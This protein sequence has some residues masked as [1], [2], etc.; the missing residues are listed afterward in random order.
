MSYDVACILNINMFQLG[1]L[2]CG[3]C[4]F[5]VLVQQLAQLQLGP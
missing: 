3:D 1:G 5:F 2:Q 4:L